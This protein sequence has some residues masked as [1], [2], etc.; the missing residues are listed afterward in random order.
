[1]TTATLTL[2]DFLRARLDEDFEVAWGGAPSPWQEG[3]W[4]QAFD[5]ARE[6]LDKFGTVTGV[7]YYGGTFGHV[8][9]FDPTRV[10]KDIE[11]KRQVMAFVDEWFADEAAD[12][13][14]LKALALPYADHPDY[15]E[16]WKP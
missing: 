5:G 3:K 4:D 15:R 14:L 11:A 10:L 9:R 13:H 7:C 6:V 1:M 12:H 8:L 2:T 16:E